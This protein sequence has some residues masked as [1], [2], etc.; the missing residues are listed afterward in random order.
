MKRA[1]KIWNKLGDIDVFITSSKSLPTGLDR[2]QLANLA[3]ISE[4]NVGGIIR[5]KLPNPTGLASPLNRNIPSF[6]NGGRT[7][8][9]LPEWV[10]PNQP[11]GNFDF[12][13]EFFK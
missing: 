12:S 1:S 13:L 9:G 10:I 7:A 8:G 2:S 11:I 6:M 4:S 5:F 3:T